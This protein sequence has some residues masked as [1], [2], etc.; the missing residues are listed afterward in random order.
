MEHW[1]IIRTKVASSSVL[2]SA[3]IQPGAWTGALAL[4]RSI[5]KVRRDDLPPAPKLIIK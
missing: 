1:R 2:T 3:M 4:I 5:Q